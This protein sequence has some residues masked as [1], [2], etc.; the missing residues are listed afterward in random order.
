M[1][2]SYSS[3]II[4]KNLITNLKIRVVKKI[5]NEK[6][7]TKDLKQLEYYRNELKKPSRCF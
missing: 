5:I 6:S 7:I 3:K 1:A 4:I 2:L